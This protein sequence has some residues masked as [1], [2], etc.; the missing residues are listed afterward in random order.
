MVDRFYIT[1]PIY[2]VNDRPHIGHLYTTTIADVLARSGAVIVHV[3]VV[4]AQVDRAIRW[5]A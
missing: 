3:A 5:R 2:Y 1:T 4:C